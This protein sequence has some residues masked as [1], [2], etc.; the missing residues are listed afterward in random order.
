MEYTVKINEFEGPLDLL[1][2]L[3]KKMKIDIWDISIEEVT[4]SYLD[5]IKT[6]EDLNLDIASEYLVMAAELIELKSRLLLPSDETDEDEYEEDPKEQ[7]IKKLIEYKKYKELTSE[8]RRLEEDRSFIFTKEPEDYK[9]YMDNDKD[10]SIIGEVNAV[11]LF[12]AF[13]NLLQKK[14]FD[15]P[16]EKKVTNKDISINERRREIKEII[17]KN[18][19]VS[20][21]DLFD[22]KDKDYLITTFL[23]ILDMVKHMEIYVNQSKNF[24]NIF[25]SLEESD[26]NE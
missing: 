8:F 12:T 2:H 26:S 19:K 6:M 20:F 9:L 25:L 17:E 21:Y 10:M 14:E 23:A 5:Y 3:I 24:E 13:Q 1:L 4:K 7:L 16:L 18:K 15:K 22:K 11:D